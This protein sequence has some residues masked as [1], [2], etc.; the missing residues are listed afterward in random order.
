MPRTQLWGVVLIVAAAGAVSAQTAPVKPAEEV[1]KNIV[2]LKGVP[3]DQIAPAMQFISASLGVNCEFCHVPGKPEADDKGTKKTARMMMQMTATINKNAFNGRQQITCNSC[4]NGAQRPNASP[5]V[6]EADMPVHSA[7]M[8]APAGGGQQQPSVDDI[9]TKY[10]SAVGGAEA[11]QKITSRAMKGT[12][13]AMGGNTPIDVYT[14]APNMRVTVTHNQNGDSYTAFDGKAGWMGSTGRPAREMSSSESAASAID[15]EFNLALH[16][17]DMYPQLRR[18][19]PETVDGVECD[20]IN[21]QAQGKPAVR[22]YFDK[23]TGL[24][25]RQVRF[26]D[27]PMGRMPT[28][29]D[30]ADYKAVDGVKIPMK[31][32]LSRPNGRF[33]ITIAD[34]KDNAPIEDSKFAKPSGEVK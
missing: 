20:V 18:G 22:L 4:H 14:K 11:M 21:G 3:A 16:I 19:R 12:I 25:V 26:A 5:K 29:I 8:A 13:A 7:A 1:F 17:K 27:T 31:W 33:T 28:Q 6:M 32:T 24:L 15:A 10:T 9:L 30:Y 34:V 23:S 2:E